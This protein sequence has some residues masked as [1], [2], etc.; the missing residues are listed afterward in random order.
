MIKFLIKSVAMF[1]LN[2]VTA[3]AVLLFLILLAGN[4]WILTAMEFALTKTAGFKTSVGKSSDSIF[5]GCFDL[6]DFMI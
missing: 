6:K 2:L 4:F 3:A 5:R 1:A